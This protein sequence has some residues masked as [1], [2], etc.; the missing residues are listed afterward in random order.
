MRIFLVLLSCLL[1]M[2]AGYAQQEKI[3]FYNIEL[4]QFRDS[5]LTPY[6]EVY[7]ALDAGMLHYKQQAGGTWEADVTVSYQFLSTV[8]GKETVI[9]Q[10]SFLV[11]PGGLTDTSATA[12]RFYTTHIKRYTLKPGEYS[13]RGTVTDN[14]APQPKKNEFI[15][16]FFVDE[17]KT[18]P[19]F[20]DILYVSSVKKNIQ[21]SPE[22]K[23]GLLIEPRLNG[24]FF[25]NAD[26]LKFYTECYHANTLAEKIV[27]FNVSIRQANDSGPMPGMQKLIKQKPSKVMAVSTGFNIKS[28]TDQIYYLSIRAYNE[29]QEVIAQTEQKFYIKN[30]S[31]NSELT[32][33]PQLYDQYFKYDEVTLTGYI[34]SLRYISQPMEIEFAK[35]LATFDQKK[36]YFYNFWLNRRTDPNDNVLLK[37][38]NYK[39]RVDYAN[40]K[41]ATTNRLG[42]ETD[43]GRVF[44]LYGQ[45]NDIDFH[46]YGEQGTYPYEIWHFNQLGQQGNVMFVFYNRDLA[47]GDFKLLHSNKQGEYNNPR[48]QQDLL[49][50]STQDYNLDN[51]KVNGIFSNPI[52]YQGPR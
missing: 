33:N 41:W 39:N 25:L 49:K 29:K 4:A 19:L 30:F 36:A 17:A 48:W 7:L 45:P 18:K 3:I 28:L 15:L 20:S 42:W 13:L 50:R 2:Y 10:E 16:D 52:E 8:D 21:N 51:D 27:M 12:L 5:T 43:R 34:A 31:F 1:G 32:A 6:I 26:S 22:G 44:L 23:Y 47:Y 46:L 9:Q 11:G 38:I 37:W 40:Q 24:G 35:S 14:F